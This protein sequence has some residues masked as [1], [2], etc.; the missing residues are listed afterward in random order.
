M[1]LLFTF[2]SF[3]RKE[4]DSSGYKKCFLLFS[5]SQMRSDGEHAMRAEDWSPCLGHIDAQAACPLPI[6][7]QRQC[8]ARPESRVGW[9][10]CQGPPA[11]VQK[12]AEDAG[13]TNALPAVGSVSLDLHSLVRKRKSDLGVLVVILPLSPSSSLRIQRVSKHIFGTAFDLR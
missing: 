7:A 5:P 10:S 8:A 4:G 6:P 1:E 9:H 13:A 12:T 11:H 2:L 3:E